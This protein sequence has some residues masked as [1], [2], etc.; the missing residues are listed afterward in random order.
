MREEKR[1]FFLESLIIY[2]IRAEDFTNFDL[3]FKILNILCFMNLKKIYLKTLDK[4]IIEKCN[5]GYVYD[6]TRMDEKIEFY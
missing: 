1:D 5:R 2:L 3:N 4:K 6:D